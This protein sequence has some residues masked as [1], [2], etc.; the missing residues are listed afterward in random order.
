MFTIK[1]K[2]IVQ[3]LQKFVFIK[4]GH[5][6]TTINQKVMIAKCHEQL[7]FYLIAHKQLFVPSIIY[8][9]VSDYRN[10]VHIYMETMYF[11]FYMKI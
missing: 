10:I 8:A 3:L 2:T 4:R 7:L 11:C 1:Y 6:S 9:Q 5:I